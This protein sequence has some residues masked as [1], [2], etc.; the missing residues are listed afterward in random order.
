MTAD[1]YPLQMLLVT[2]AGWVN[3]H[4]KH[5]I[6]YLLEENRVLKEQVKGR[7][8]RLTDDQR[9]RLA[10]KGRR[11]CRRRSVRQLIPCF[12]PRGDSTATTRPTARGSGRGCPGE[13]EPRA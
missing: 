3:R 7:R 2:L 12:R 9:R 11:L 10:V 6:E 5:V 13:R 4:Q 8:L 1:V